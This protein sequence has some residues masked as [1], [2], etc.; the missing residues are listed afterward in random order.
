MHLDSDE[1]LQGCDALHDTLAAARAALEALA[2][3][4][5]SFAA[6]VRVQR[7]STEQARAWVLAHVDL[8][9]LPAIPPDPSAYSARD[10]ATDE[11]L[12]RALAGA[13]SSGPAPVDP[14]DAE[15]AILNT[16][17]ALADPLSDLDLSDEASFD[18]EYISIDF[19]DGDYSDTF[20]TTDDGPPSSPDPSESFVSLRDEGESS[21]NEEPDLSAPDDDAQ[22]GDEEVDFEPYTGEEGL[23]SF[24]GTEE[25][26]PLDPPSKEEGLI[27]FDQESSLVSLGD[28]EPLIQYEEEKSTGLVDLGMEDSPSVEP[29]DDDP[30]SVATPIPAP[31]RTPDGK[32]EHT[33]VADLDSLVQLQDMLADEDSVEGSAPGA[34]ASGGEPTLSED[35]LSRLGFGSDQDLLAPEGTDVDPA[36]ETGSGPVVVPTD[37]EPDSDEPSPVGVRVGTGR[38]APTRSAG[39]AV[40]IPTIRDQRPAGASARPAAAAIRINPDGGGTSVFE[41]PE[42]L[43]LGAAD[44]EDLD[45]DSVAGFSLMVEEYEYEDDEDDEDEIEEL[46]D[47]ESIESVEAPAPAP[48]PSLSNKELDD[49]LFKAQEVMDKGDMHKAI[50]LY[51]DALDFDPDHVPAYVGRGLTWL[52]LSDYS[53]AMSDFTNAED[54]AP[55]NADVNAAFGKLYYD[56]KEYGRAIDYLNRAVKLDPRHAMAWCRRGISHYYRKDYARAHEDLVKAEGLDKNIPNIRTYISMVKKRMK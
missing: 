2:A 36:S 20:V 41:E 19:A 40:S 46:D 12:Q 26:S 48:M 54:L 7:E 18:D 45:D 11:I 39:A 31:K 35:D 25:E 29:P 33:L 43:A 49:M 38:P 14:S 51:S 10:D 52:E 37:H 17:E 6:Q 34:G 47:P 53:R 1:I 32:S 5:L 3:A 15:P 28:D 50:E 27:S 21:S 22:G 30:D 56:R 23:I 44:E 4:N 13:S 55:D 16:D 42:T 24:D 8:A 9:P